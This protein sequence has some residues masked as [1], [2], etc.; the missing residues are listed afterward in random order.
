M[1]AR[2][3]H[4]DSDAGRRSLA[5]PER[6][7][8]VSRSV[9]PVGELIRFVLGPEGEVVPDVKRRLPGRGIWV[10]ATRAAVAEAVKRRAF[11]R[12]FKREVRVAGDLAD[13]VE[14]LLARAALDALAIAY[15]AGHVV[16]GF[17]RVEAALAAEPVTALIEASDAAPDGQRKLLA[18]ARRR[19]IG[20]E[21]PV[22]ITIFTSAQLDLALGRS[23]VVHAALLARSAG[24]GVLSRC[25]SLEHFRT[26]G[27]EGRA[28]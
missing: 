22:L 7:C 5:A 6:L 15:K 14:R 16:A 24:D 2:T 13:S 23:N 26:I 12:G 17:T 19:G 28:R 3:S 10:T 9:K 27:P 20:A 1:L 4:D 8:V 25:R 18:A 21:E 11:A